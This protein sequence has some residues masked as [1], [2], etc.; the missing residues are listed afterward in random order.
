MDGVGKDLS[1][2]LI[3]GATN[4]PWAIDQ[5]VRRRFEKRV[6]IPLPDL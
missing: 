1:G 5:A 3:L 2:V 4:C 6:Y